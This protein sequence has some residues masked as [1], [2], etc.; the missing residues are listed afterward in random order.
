MVEKK[1]TY[2]DKFK[3]CINEV[4]LNSKLEV[5][6]VQNNFLDAYDEEYFDSEAVFFYRDNGFKIP[7]EIKEFCCFPPDNLILS[8]VA[9]NNIFPFE[10]SGGFILRELD[11]CLNFKE[12]KFIIYNPDIDEA[13]KK[14][15]SN[16][17]YF[18]AQPDI[19][20]PLATLVERKGDNLCLWYLKDQKL[21]KL[22]IDLKMYLD[23]LLL[24]K[25]ITHWQLF[26]C[27]KVDCSLEKNIL[28]TIL[29]QT[30]QS[31]EILFPNKNFEMLK[32]RYAYY[33]SC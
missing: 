5:N 1:G 24:T 14:I 28:K 9:T 13:T 6:A 16:C 2:I 20:P 10:V 7:E 15:L 4:L 19:S 27:E 21:Y 25:G 8:W 18:D 23:M 32:K 17:F 11:A 3:Q 33:F 12:N 29:T 30:L 26:F 31:L 22:N